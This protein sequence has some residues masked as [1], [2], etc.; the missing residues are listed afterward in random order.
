M[1]LKDDSLAAMDRMLTDPD[2]VANL[3][4][5][6]KQPVMNQTA[7]KAIMAVLSANQAAHHSNLEDTK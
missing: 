4:L 2:Q 7:Q 3:I 6:G 5:L 1:F